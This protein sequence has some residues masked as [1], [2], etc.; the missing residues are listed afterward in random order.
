MG[1]S[2]GESYTSKED[3]AHFVAQSCGMKAGKRR[4]FAPREVI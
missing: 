4:R 3:L 1:G 2:R